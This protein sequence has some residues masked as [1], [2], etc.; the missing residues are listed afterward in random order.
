MTK[1]TVAF[2]DFAN[3]PTKGLKMIG[4][5]NKSNCHVLMK[6]YVIAFASSN[7]SCLL[8]PQVTQILFVSLF[9]S[10]LYLSPYRVPE[11]RLRSSHGRNKTK[12]SQE[13]LKMGNISVYA[14]LCY[15]ILISYV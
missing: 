1:L 10:P 8:D 11:I 2:R 14:M 7:K 15:L 9:G 3:A 12:V 5:H 13:A 4:M 6:P